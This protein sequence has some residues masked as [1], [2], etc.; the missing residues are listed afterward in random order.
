MYHESP[1]KTMVASAALGKYLRVTFGSAG[2][3][4][5]MILAGAA[6]EEIGVTENRC[7]AALEEIPVRLR[8]AQGTGRYVAAAPIA[9]GAVV[10][11]AAAGKVT[12]GGTD[13]IIGT[14][15]EAATA[16]NDIIEV[17]RLN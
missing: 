15:M 4:G 16:D 3:A 12:T 9:I 8:T 10:R 13:P 14:A 7:F 11:R 6:V 2:T 17:L 1:I 5:Q